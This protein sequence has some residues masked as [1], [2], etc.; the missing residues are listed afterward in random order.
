MKSVLPLFL[1]ATCLVAPVPAAPEAEPFVPLPLERVFVGED[2]FHA[3]LR[4]ARANE[5]AEL[6]F[7]DRI[8]AIGKSFVGIPY[9]NFTLEIDDHIEAPS[10]N[11][12][13]MDCWTFFEIAL[14][15][16]RMLDMPPE[17]HTPET[18]LQLIELDR[19]RDGQCD[20]S[21][22]SR[23]HYLED[24]SRDNHR[25]DL[26]V[27]LTRDL[28]GI[29]AP[30][31]CREM[32]IG[33]KHYRYMRHNPHWRKGIR[34]MEE[35]VENESH[36]YIPKDKVPAIEDQLRNGDIIGIYSRNGKRISTSHVGIALRDE[37][38]TLRFMHATTQQQYGRSV[39]IDSRLSDYLNRFSKHAGIL[40]ARPSP[41]PPNFDLSAATSGIRHF[42]P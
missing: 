23:L 31:R 29:R 3:F 41:L 25:R 12:D 6:A 18:L 1:L 22:L 28:G 34:Q 24:W 13:G 37:D 4:D 16:A 27:D 14:A 33:W 36:F 39:A 30:L 9:E 8:V 10:V 5:W 42:I 26:V 38:G 2:R 11:F 17:A 15:L 19:Y 35:R 40:V 21:Y 20:S 7:P 32:T